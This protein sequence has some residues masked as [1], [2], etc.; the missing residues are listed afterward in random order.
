MIGFKSQNISSI[1]KKTK[2][3]GIKYCYISGN[4]DHFE[5]STRTEEDCLYVKKLLYELENSLT[6][7]KFNLNVRN[8]KSIGILIG[9]GGKN[10]KELEEKYN[11][12]IS[13]KNNETNYFVIISGFESHIVFE[14]IQ[15]RILKIDYQ[16]DKQNE[17]IEENKLKGD[18][19]NNILINDDDGW[20]NDN[21]EDK[22][23]DDDSNN[24]K[25]SESKIE[26]FF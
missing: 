13:I 11:V 16:I 24:S 17:R 14:F 15:Q 6:I 10:L 26:S 21:K 22:N 3:M 20:N 9:T 18:I 5:I 7:K 12:H 1:I 2:E 4:G 23:E 25:S 8:E 19:M